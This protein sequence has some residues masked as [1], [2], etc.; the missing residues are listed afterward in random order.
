MI[1][2][3]DRGEFADVR[4]GSI[5]SFWPSVGRSRS[6]S[7]NGHS[8]SLSHVSKVP[9][10][11]A[12]VIRP[13]CVSRR[14]GTHNPCL[15]SGRCL[16]RDGRAVSCTHL[17]DGRFP[18]ARHAQIARRA[19]LS[20]LSALAPSGKSR[21]C[22]RASRLDEEG[23]FGRSS[24]YVGRGCDGREWHVGRTWRTR[25]AKSCGPGAPKQ[26]LRSRDLSRERRWQPSDGHR[27]ERDINRNT[28][29]QGMPDGRRNT[30]FLY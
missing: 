25:T 26:A 22:S 27:G 29:A 16:C 21:R 5:A 13:T 10:A 15:A 12:R 24:R 18:H 8:Q 6:T 4:V 23:R 9:K 14:D 19:N 30:S 11:S 3:G 1:C 17:P 20:Q 7:I 2:G 28:I